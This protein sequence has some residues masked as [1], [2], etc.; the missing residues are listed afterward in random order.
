MKRRSFIH[1]TIAGSTGI[2]LTGSLFAIQSCKSPNGKIVMALIGSGARGMGTIIGTCKNNEN[3]EIKTVCDVNDFKASKALNQIEKEL[4]HKPGRVKN[5]KEVFDDQDIDAVMISTPEHW[6]TLA[7]VWACQADKHVYVE[8]NPTLSI[9]EGQKLMEAQKKYKRVVQI[10]FQ[11]RSVPYAYSAREFIQSGKLGQIMHVK[12]YNMLGPSSWKRVPDSEIPEG[13]DW[14]AWLGPAEYR[15]YNEGVHDMRSRGGWTN[16]WD[17]S[18][19]TMADDASHILDLTRLVLGD[20]GHPK[21]IYG[22][23][24]NHVFGV[25]REVPEFQSVTYEFEKFAL[26][27]ESGNATRYLKKTSNKIRH[28]KTE[29]PDWAQNATRIEIY[30]T[31]GL[32]Y[33]GRHGGGWQVV[34]EKGE[35][36]AEEYGDHPDKFHQQN[37]IESIR[38]RK[39]P[40]SNVLQGHLSAS[41]VHLG[42]I[43]Y[44]VGNKQL[45]FDPEN[46]VFPDNDE[47]NKLLKT[48]YREKYKMPDKV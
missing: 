28:S 27:C 30:G 16:Y 8:K 13:L 1:K 10:G 17:F 48:T 34:G 36:L 32:M 20:P 35:I 43:C 23:G 18:G 7:A 14:D 22:W 37:F 25:N 5:M 21:S 2:A 24:G 31:D 26:T 33:L 38:N 41:L 42:N 11:N 3:V 47:A 15:P 9:W 45:I 19:G 40:N 12:T 29:L 4:G 6:H 46:E 44:R 39:D